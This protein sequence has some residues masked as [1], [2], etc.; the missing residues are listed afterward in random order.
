[1]VFDDT[2]NFLYD[3]IVKR[4]ELKKI[5]LAASENEKHI[6]FEKL[7]S[8]T[9]S[10]GGEMFYDVAMLKHV[11]GKKIYKNKNPYLIPDSCLIYLTHRL[12]FESEI[13]LLWGNLEEEENFQEIFYN[14]LKDCIFEK[15]ELNELINQVLIDYVPYAKYSSLFDMILFPKK[16]DMK[17]IQGTNYYLPMFFYGISE[18]EVLERFG[19]CLQEAVDFLY[20]KCHK[21]FETIF[22]NFIYNK[23]SS[24]KKI[25]KK[26]YEFVKLELKELLMRYIPTESSLG[27]R[28]KG[29]MV[30]DWISQGDLIMAMFNNE[31][32]DG[33][34]LYKKVL[35]EVSM[36]Y[37]KCLEK[38]QQ[39]TINTN[40][41]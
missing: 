38:L 26:I 31:K 1:M 24:L 20:K 6:T 37:V 28:V 27:V 35:Y 34:L 30:S 4:L 12:S 10:D 25:D 3:T 18:D 9:K 14:L 39:A 36:E 15:N 17:K 23:G 21:E 33:E 32:L 5:K 41:D 8:Y 16:F 13:E 2:V 29:I 19:P 7:S 22:K 40:N 11:F